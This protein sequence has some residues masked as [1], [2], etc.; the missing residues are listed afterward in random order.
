[1]WCLPEPTHSPCGI[2]VPVPETD[3][4]VDV[5]ERQ[6]VMDRGRA[7]GV[8]TTRSSARQTEI[9]AVESLE[10]LALAF[11]RTGTWFGDTYR[12]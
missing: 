5:V 8:S 7:D 6:G 1:M 12:G 2:P 3:G 10:W 4:A 9:Q 11:T